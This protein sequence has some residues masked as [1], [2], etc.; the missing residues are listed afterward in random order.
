[1]EFGLSTAFEPT[2]DDVC[3]AASNIGAPMDIDAAD[4]Y[5]EKLGFEDRLEIAESALQAD[6]LDEQA[7]SAQ[8][9]IEEFLRRDGFGVAP[10]I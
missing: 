1:M 8:G 5:L 10:T 4:A 3:A 6:D 2:A 9:K 7:Q